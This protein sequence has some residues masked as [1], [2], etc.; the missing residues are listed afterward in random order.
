MGN[1]TSCQEEGRGNYKQ[2]TSSKKSKNEVKTQKECESN[3]VEDYPDLHVEYHNGD[4]Y[5]NGIIVYHANGIIVYH[6][7]GNPQ[8]PRVVIISMG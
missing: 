1:Q 3:A 6:A 4:V 2:G 5:I 8:L 7:A